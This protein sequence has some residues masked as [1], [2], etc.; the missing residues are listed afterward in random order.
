LSSEII[1][2]LAVLIAAFVLF[3][4]GWVRMDVVALAVL[5]TLAITGLVDSSEALS[6][7]GHPAVITVWA[8]FVLGE[9]LTRAGIAER[10]G[11]IVVRAAGR[12]EARTIAIFMLAGGTMSAFMN[13]IGVGA[14]LL[15]VAAGVARRTGVAP[16]RI[17]M[18]LA[19]G[20]LLG[21]LMTLIGTP[22]NL[23]VSTALRD[24]GLRGFGFFDFAWIGLPALL[25]ATA[26]VAVIGRHLLPRTDTTR[27]TATQDE[28]RAQ[29]RLQERMVSL[30]LP[31]GARLAG[32]T[33][34]QSGLGSAVGLMVIALTRAGRTDA[35]PHRD[36]VLRGGDVL[37][38]QG[39][40]DRLRLLG[41]WS[42]LGI[43]RDPRI[44]R[45]LLAQDDTLA[46]VE[47]AAQSALV[48]KPL[49]VR[50]LRES[51]AAHVL[52]VRRGQQLH[53][54]GLSKL[55]IEAGD[56]LLAWGAQSAIAAL[57][58]VAGSTSVPLTDDAIHRIEQSLFVLAVPPDSSLIGSTPGENRLGDA[59]EFR[60]LAV[61][62]EGIRLD[63]RASQAVLAA[64]DLLL[65]QGS[66][67]DVE[68]LRGLQ[69]LEVLDESAS[70][71]EVLQEGDLELVEATLHPH[72]RLAGRTVA[73]LQL[74]ERYR[75]RVAGIWR[76]GKARLSA[77]GSMRVERGDAILVVGPRQRLAAL[78]DDEDLIVLD[79]V[80]EK[81]IDSTKAPLAGLLMA[82]VVVSVLVGALPIAIAAVAG[83]T[84]MVL[85][86]C[87]TMEQAYRA[88][89]WRSIF[90][91]AGM[92]PLGAAMQ[93]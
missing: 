63:G 47:V 22:P 66:D 57:G 42:A 69:Q 58:D 35:L 93:Q 73:E 88:I 61:F 37:L 43:E 11:R 67:E 77:L 91:I 5:S 79:P 53:R 46:E 39:R 87:L 24:A 27:A 68:M 62:R 16:S 12:S 54:S 21:G 49:H 92:L 6:S 23:L 19:Y 36:T 86:R 8:M 38:A 71:L 51:T 32:R 20:T 48:G 45:T 28:L 75:V 1:L 74:S 13:N 4:G 33:L 64:G 90:L 18:P 59:F 82:A 83:A 41:R 81:P 25:V 72:S 29:Y 15:P 26:Y 3:V 31:D 14:L 34:A 85:T 9:G 10:I 80:Q 60:L 55:T 52:S 76:D 44:V 50:A 70:Y 2:V 65:V 17:L 56:R 40:L 7:F 89:D 30:R 84:L 78:A